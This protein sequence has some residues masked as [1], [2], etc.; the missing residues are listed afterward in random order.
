M[1]MMAMCSAALAQNKPESPAKARTGD[2]LSPSEHRAGPHDL[3]G[4][5]LE[6]PIP[7]GPEGTYPF[8]LVIA[9][10]RHEIRRFHG[11]SFV[12]KWAFVADGQQVA[13]ESGPLHFSMTCVLADIASGRELE[14]YDCYQDLPDN[15]PKWVRAL[16]P[17]L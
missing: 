6:G 14:R 5:T 7:G 8:V 4:W 9:H 3:E 10:N 17:L 11:S 12:W 16:E 2:G 1:M 15:A 13:Y